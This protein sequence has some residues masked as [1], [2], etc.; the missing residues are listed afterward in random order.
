M[1]W[2][3]LA[4]ELADALTIEVIEIEGGT[5]RRGRN[6]FDLGAALLRAEEP[7]DR[8]REEFAE[9]LSDLADGSWTG[10]AE[11]LLDLRWP[12][13]PLIDFDWLS[14]DWLL[15]TLDVGDGWLYLCAASAGGEVFEAHARVKGGSAVWAALFVDMC[16]SNGDTYDMDM[17]FPAQLPEQ[18][19]NYS[20]S[21]LPKAAV[22]EGF[23]RGLSDDQQAWE[24]IAEA[25]ELWEGTRE[26]THPSGEQEI[27]EADREMLLDLYFT[28]YYDE[29]PAI[30]A[31][32]SGGKS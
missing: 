15:R 2:E 32:S 4:Q 18:V 29:E 14:D 23:R 28:Y 7:G 22:R 21:L 25:L 1:K 16:A 10:M 19:H 6:A 12:S 27:R 24:Q 8:E 31:L 20:P 13:R 26:P 3:Q 11:E 17:F 30:S 5:V 9:Y